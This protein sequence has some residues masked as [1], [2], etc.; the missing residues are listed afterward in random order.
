LA[1]TNVSFHYVPNGINDVKRVKYVGTAI[2]D[3]ASEVLFDVKATAE[4][5]QPS[6]IVSPYQTFDKNSK[7][8]VP[9]VL[10]SEAFMYFKTMIW[11]DI[12]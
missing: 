2:L 3:G 7:K 8:F 9:Q 4:V 11:N 5:F 1:E 10:Q 6:P 12:K